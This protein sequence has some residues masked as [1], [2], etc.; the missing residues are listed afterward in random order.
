MIP[1]RPDDTEQ[2]KERLLPPVESKSIATPL[3]E[4]PSQPSPATFRRWRGVL[5]SILGILLPLAGGFLAGWP[6][7]RLGI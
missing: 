4:K 2:G 7:Y 1:Q 6:W 5:L 3:V